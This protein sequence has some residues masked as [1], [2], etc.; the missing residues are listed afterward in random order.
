MIKK[1]RVRNLQ[2]LAS[3]ELELGMVTVLVGDS[4]VGKTATL[5][6]IRGL[7][8]NWTPASL[9]RNGES[10]LTVTLTLDDGTEVIW[11]RGSG[12]NQYTLKGHTYKNVG[13]EAPQQVLDLLG[14]GTRRILGV[15]FNPNFRDQF[16]MP[17][18][19]YDTEGER[20]IKLG[21]ISGVGLLQTAVRIASKDKKSYESLIKQQTARTLSLAESVSKFKY[22]DELAKCSTELARV[23]DELVARSGKVTKITTLFSLKAEIFVLPKLPTNMERLKAATHLLEAR[24]ELRERPV[25]IES[26]GFAALV[27]RLKRAAELLSLRK[28]QVLRNQLLSVHLQPVLKMVAVMAMIEARDKL[29]VLTGIYLAEQA[30]VCTLRD[31]Y[32][33]SLK[34]NGVCPFCNSV[35][36][37]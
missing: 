5:R 10:A 14:F 4:N 26:K 16:S 21:V 15:E 28:A 33:R 8:E 35:L 19:V 31:T 27:S 24:A 29:R 30:R 20:L 23:R 25:L 11:S 12:N 3:L 2:S 36:A 7:I 13:R 18:L 6:G 9:L 37:K 34:A 1:V 22:L 32:E 17:A